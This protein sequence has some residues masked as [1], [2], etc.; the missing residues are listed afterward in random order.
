MT[1]QLW[2]PFIHEVLHDSSVNTKTISKAKTSAGS[3]YV[4]EKDVSGY[5]ESDQS[6][7]KLA[8]SCEVTNIV[9]LFIEGVQSWARWDTGAQPGTPIAWI[10]AGE[11]DNPPE[12]IHSSFGVFARHGVVVLTI[13]GKPTYQQLKQ[14]VVPGAWDIWLVGPNGG[15]LVVKMESEYGK[16]LPFDISKVLSESGYKV[17]LYKGLE[18]RDTTGNFIIYYIESPSGGKAW[19]AESWSIGT[20]GGSQEIWITYQQKDA[21]ILLEKE[22]SLGKQHLLWDRESNKA[23]KTTEN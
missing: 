21:D 16:D 20:A 2:W 5:S 14:T 7:Q 4:V 9:R 13:K 15:V 23:S 1:Y 6:L 17:T 8:G 18:V 10:T 3:N 19:L 22:G 11:Y 12:D